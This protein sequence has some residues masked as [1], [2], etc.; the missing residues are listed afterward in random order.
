[1]S[2]LIPEGQT[3]M[4]SRIIRTSLLATLLIAALTIGWVPAAGAQAPV[5]PGGPVLVVDQGDGFADYYAEILRAEGLNEF[6][7]GPLTA[8]SLA[9]HQVVLLSQ[10]NYAAQAAMLDTWVRGGGNLIAM[11]PTAALAGTLGLGAIQG[12][13]SNQYLQVAAGRGITGD[14]MQFHGAADLWTTAGGTTPIATLYSDEDSA[15]SSPAVTLRSLGSGQAAAFTFDLARSVVYTRQGNPAWAGMERDFVLDSLT[16]SDDLFFGARPGDI[17]PDWVNLDKVAIPQADEQQRLLADLITG[18]NADRMPLPRFWYLPRGEK[19]A[20]VMT[21][22]DHS[23][24]NTAG[25]FA[26]F[27]AESPA[28]CSVANWECIRATSYVFPNTPIPNAEALEGDG[29]EIAL[30]LH[31]GC[32]NNFTPASLRAS[33]DEQLPDWQGEFPTL[34]APVTNRTH[35]ISWSD[36]A[37]EP[38]VEHENGVRFDTNYYYWP[39][40]W[41]QNRPGMFTGSGFPMRFANTD[42][43][44][45]DVYQATTQLTDESDIDYGLHI[46]ALLDGALGPQGYYGVFTANMHT[47]SPEHDGANAIVAAAKARGV[48]VVSSKQMLT[49]LDGRNVSSFDGLGFSSNVLQFSIA[50]GS[51]ANGLQAMLPVEGPTGALTGVKRGGATVTTTNRTVGGTDYV[52]FDA[53][54]GAYTATY[55]DPPVAPVPDT[56]ITDL[57]VAGSTATA[58]FASD[59]AGASFQCSLDGAAFSACGSPVQLT[60]LADGAHTFAVRALGPGGTDATP[61]AR[62]FAIVPATSPGTNTPPAGGGETGGTGTKP[63]GGVLD[64][65]VTSD[66]SAPRM[67][68][69]TRRARANADG[70]VKLRATCPQGEVRCRVTL[71]LRL[72]GRSIGTRT[73]ALAGGETKRFRIQLRRSARRELANEGSLRVTAAA[74]AR[75]DAGNE[76]TVRTAVRL[77]A[78]RGR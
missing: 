68:L 30:H 64:D 72:H 11:R 41:V 71:R 42:G 47:D 54:A 65:N 49:W 59:V 58:S 76:A 29:F 16:R 37:S 28:G 31:A 38:I 22:D 75:D 4:S 18:M 48:P 10:G 1:M 21:G 62:T 52:L 60:G 3:R 32:P 44:L 46:A 24:G 69:R 56:S 33:W 50:P 55:G 78:P 67:V 26:R 13:L 15:T 63:G 61:A 43:S 17:Q 39:G 35:C 53:T 25:Q 2:S 5:A 77:L 57:S 73:L 8:Q 40:E 66:R 9:S 6:D 19:A 70:V 34:N 20:V 23:T 14:T 12:A 27:K 74:T 51:G 7:V 36:W 45:I